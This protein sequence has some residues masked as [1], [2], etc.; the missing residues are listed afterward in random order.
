[1][2]ND[3]AATGKF[4]DILNTRNFPEAKGRRYAERTLS[5]IL[6]DAQLTTGTRGVKRGGRRVK[7]GPRDQRP[8]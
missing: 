7:L 4:A 6:Y 3:G 2:I 5:V 8:R 1:M